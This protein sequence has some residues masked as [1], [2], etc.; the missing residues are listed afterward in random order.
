MHPLWQERKT[1][2]DINFYFNTFTGQI[3]FNF[4]RAFDGDPL[5]GGGILA[6]QMGLGKTIMLLSLILDKVILIKLLILLFYKK[7]F[8]LLRFVKSHTTLK[9][10]KILISK[11]S[12]LEAHL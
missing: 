8:L 4:P 3:S 2:N 1:K 9:R 10:K 7:L 11:D 5:C 12:S 6:D